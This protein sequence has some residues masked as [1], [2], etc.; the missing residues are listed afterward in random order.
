MQYSDFHN[1]WD[2]VIPMNIV[3]RLY[4]ELFDKS[5]IKD[6]LTFMGIKTNKF[7]KFNNI[8]GLFARL[9]L[10][11]H[12]KYIYDELPSFKKPPQRLS[13]C[14]EE[15]YKG[16]ELY[17]Y[18]KNGHLLP[19]RGAHMYQH[20]LIYL[21]AVNA[22]IGGDLNI[23]NSFY[24]KED[25]KMWDSKKK[26][27]NRY[28]VPIRY[29]EIL[30]HNLF[31]EVAELNL[32]GNPRVKALCKRGVMKYLKA[33]KISPFDDA[34]V[35]RS[36][37]KKMFKKEVIDDPWNKATA[38]F[39]SD[40][41]RGKLE[42]VEMSQPEKKIP[43]KEEGYPEHYGYALKWLCLVATHREYMGGK[44]D[45]IGSVAK[46]HIT[47][48]VGTIGVGD[49]IGID[50]AGCEGFEYKS[51]QT[52]III[53]HCLDEL[54]KRRLRLKFNPVLRIHVGEG[55]GTSD[56]GWSYIEWAPVGYV[57]SLPN[58][59]KS[60]LQNG[61]KGAATGHRLAREVIKSLEKLPTIS[62]KTWGNE[63]KNF[64]V[65]KNETISVEIKE[66][67]KQNVKVVLDS[68]IEYYTNADSLGWMKMADVCIRLGHVTHISD[69]DAERMA[70]HKIAGDF[71]LSSNMRTGVLGVLGEYEEADTLKATGGRWN[72]IIKNKNKFK[73]HGIVKLMKE[74]GLWVLGTDGQGVEV[75]D[76]EGE[77]K[78][79]YAVCD[80]YKEITKNNDPF[81]TLNKNIDAIRQSYGG[82]QNDE[83]QQDL[84][85]TSE[86][87][88]KITEEL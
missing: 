25:Y 8:V 80:Q 41:S 39:L 75:T 34:F 36:A 20:M 17:N 14:M 2:G 62:G 74:K 54:H 6:E 63:S 33:T 82:G 87:L 76:L 71:N 10:R 72:D 31:N 4:K 28:D 49:V 35:A 1:H 50:L 7:R 53:N 3:I 30:L 24:P 70:A 21:T 78:G 66:R 11:I 65:L 67:A 38:S 40:D 85:K 52:K 5:L 13:S 68:I 44:N 83:R 59:V 56:Q 29:T 16:G 42:Y 84:E 18:I 19:S 86:H 81:A 32:I 15:C 57:K 46:K 37:F 45:D 9:S 58:I 23:D 26:P 48:A 12:E 55:A 22:L 77:Y 61:G 60:K 69:R 47:E 43:W 79:C 73:D 88:K 51:K 64:T 27:K